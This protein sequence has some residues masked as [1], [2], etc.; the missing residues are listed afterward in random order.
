MHQR[1]PSR[2]RGPR[3]Y[4]GGL[5]WLRLVYRKCSANIMK[6]TKNRAIVCIR[7]RRRVDKDTVPGKK[8]GRGIVAECRNLEV[9]RIRSGILLC[10]VITNESAEVQDL[11]GHVAE[12][13]PIKF[14]TQGHRGGATGLD[15]PP[16]V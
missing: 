15:I 10:K 16:N 11:P 13:M 9:I 8:V 6:R 5:C 12:H 14:A 7:A 1:L 4:R 3:A 2:A